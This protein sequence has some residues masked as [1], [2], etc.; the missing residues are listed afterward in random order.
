MQRRGDLAGFGELGRNFHLV[1][2]Y[3]FQ[4]DLFARVR[5]TSVALACECHQH[6]FGL[7]SQRF[8]WS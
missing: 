8:C 5:A 6:Y 2:I 7:Q 1:S 3:L 4:A